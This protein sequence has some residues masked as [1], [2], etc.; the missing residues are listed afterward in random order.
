[1]NDK[2][3]NGYGYIYEVYKTKSFSRAAENL[4]ISQSSL[5]ATIRK[6]EKRIGVEIFDRSTTPIGLTE[7][8]IEY[9]KSIE[10]IMDIE[11]EFQSHVLQLEE[12]ITGQLSIGG[13]SNSLSHTLP[14]V[15]SS[16]TRLYPGVSLRLIEGGS[17]Q[18]EKQLSEGI[19]DLVIDNRIFPEG[20]FSRVPLF[21][22]L[23]MLAVPRSCKVNE[24]LKDFQLTADDIMHQ[25]HKQKDFPIVPLNYFSQEPFLLLRSGND[26]RQ[27]AEKL[28]SH[29]GFAP[30]IV[31]KLDQQM[32]AYSLACY[33]VG[34][35]F[36]SDWV[37]M[38]M[39]SDDNLIYYRLDPEFTSRDVSIFYKSSRYLT[40]S[41]QE[42][43]RIAEGTEF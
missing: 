34:L 28:C 36:I 30:K 38:H 7:Y 15:I 41:M 35:T 3:F 31:L 23:L 33:G 6:I 18:L 40:R 32:T 10:K 29:Y 25:K 2:L 1:M 22:E 14:P 20:Q 17:Y 39:R 21:K 16:F 8:G 26:T 43:L 11:N 12:L 19:L 24:E 4:F 37:I 9:I 42:F 13:S 27:R 5:S